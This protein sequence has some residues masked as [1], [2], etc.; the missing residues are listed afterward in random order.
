ML[1]WIHLL[2]MHI[3]HGDYLDTSV[4]WYPVFLFW[5]WS[6]RIFALCLDVLIWPHLLLW[7][8]FYGLLLS[9]NTPF[10]MIMIR[11]W[12]SPKIQAAYMIITWTPL[13]MHLPCSYHALVSLFMTQPNLSISVV[14]W[15]M[16]DTCYCS[17]LCF[18]HDFAYTIMWVA[19][20]LTIS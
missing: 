1:S 18:C 6:P 5:M 12:A 8:C 10:I 3:R 20:L 13:D 7:P 15:L 19:L 9:L 14:N 11:G 4:Y 2:N 17:I 16:R